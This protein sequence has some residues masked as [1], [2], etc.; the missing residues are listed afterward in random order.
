M[1]YLA[2]AASGPDHPRISE[3]L[4]VE[5]DQTPTVRD[6]SHFASSLPRSPPRCLTPAPARTS[7]GRPWSRPAREEGLGCRSPLV[8]SGRGTTKRR[9]SPPLSL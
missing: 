4:L 2:T 9:E 6:L 8:L 5:V 1:N 3:A 7:T